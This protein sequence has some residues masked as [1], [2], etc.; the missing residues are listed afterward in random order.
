MIEYVD[1]IQLDTFGY[2][3]WVKFTEDG[4]SLKIKPSNPVLGVCGI[5]SYLISDRH[6][7]GSS[8][9]YFFRYS[10]ND[11]L[12]WSEW[13]ILN[14]LNLSLINAKKNQFFC[15]ELNLVKRGSGNSWFKSI[16]FQFDYEDPQIPQVYADICLSTKVPYWNYTSIQWALNVLNKVYKRGIVPS[17]IERTEDYIHLWW[18]II[19]PF[20]LRIAWAEIFT[21]LPWDKKLL[22]KYLESRG[23][24]VGNTSDLAEL[25][26]LMQHFYGEVAKRGTISMFDTFEIDQQGTSIRGEFLRLIDANPLDERVV[27]IVTPEEQGWVLGYSSPNGYQNTDYLVNFRKGYENTISKVENYPLFNAEKVSLSDG[28]IT[29]NSLDGFAGIGTEVDFTKSLPISTNCNYWVVVR[30]VLTQQSQIKFGCVGFD[31]LQNAIPFEESETSKNTNMFVEGTFE[32]G[33]YL[34]IGEIR[35]GK[36]DYAVQMSDFATKWNFPANKNICTLMPLFHV[37][38]VAQISDFHVQTIVDRDIYM[39]IAKEILLL[40]KNNSTYTEEEIRTIGE[41]TLLPFDLQYS[42]KLI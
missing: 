38:G 12:D 29:I 6:E 2:D 42:L 33:E 30:F 13:L 32:P 25:H 35:D 36:K 28:K 22:K 24:I 11:G 8:L 19:Y 39:S 14:D 23:L 9:E 34:F 4:D 26:Y 18:S 16:D 17:F 5:K 7:A 3:V 21:D 31:S 20:A 40:F 15:I 27:G 37:R 10:V 41:N 1:M